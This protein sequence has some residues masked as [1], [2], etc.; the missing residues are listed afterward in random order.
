MKVHLQGIG[1]RPAIYA[2]DCKPGMR[3]IYNFG[4][5]YEIVSV[6]PA[7]SGKSVKITV[8]A[9]DGKL[10]QKTMRNETLIAI[11]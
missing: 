6:D 7:K 9:D 4:Y 8:R 10:Y 1:F 3:R 5:E 11:A 2:A